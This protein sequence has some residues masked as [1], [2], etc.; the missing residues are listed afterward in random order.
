M[1]S[2]LLVR[3]GQAS[4][5]SADYDRLSHLGETQVGHL[6]DHFARIGQ[7]VDA[8]YTGALRRQ[9]STAE[10]IDG[11]TGCGLA[12]LPAFNEYDAHAL[13]E[14]HATLTGAAPAALQGARSTL[15][16]RAF[17]R[18]LEEVG[19][20][21]IKGDLDHPAVESWSEFRGRVAE[22]LATIMQ[23]EGRSRDIVISTSAGVIGAAVGHILGLDD[24]GALRLSWVV[25][26]ASV[27]R[28]RY[29]GRRCSLESF[30]GVSHLEA[31]PDP[32]RLL[33]HR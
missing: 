30:N 23:R 15:D 14:R 7:K 21:W 18:R 31:Q 11:L 4:F 2:L 10:I 20:A 22:G 8:I 28:V 5:G 32:Q 6:R 29:D 1:S 25:F 33:T 3:H 16:Q 19:R 13:I 27:T 12:T 24:E 26:N 17:Q 9:R